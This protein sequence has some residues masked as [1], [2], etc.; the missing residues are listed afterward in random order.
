MS[1]AS[2]YF[3]LDNLSG[4]KDVKKIKQELDSLPGV[5]SVSVNDRNDTVAVDYDNSG[6]EY[7]RLEG[8]IQEMGF[9]ILSEAN[10]THK[11]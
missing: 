8:K 4:K 9:R 2:V 5:L 10:Q 6:V 11:M 1:K 3:R 7:N